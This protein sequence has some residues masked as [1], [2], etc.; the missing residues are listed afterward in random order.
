[1]LSETY[2]KLNNYELAFKYNK[3]FKK[4]SDSLNIEESNQKITTLQMQNEFRKQHQLTTIQHQRSEMKHG[5]VS[6]GLLMLILVTGYLIYQQRSASKQN[7]RKQRNLELANQLLVDELKFKKNLMEDNINYLMNKNDILTSTIE[8]LNQL[9]QTVKTEN[10]KLLNEVILELR[11]GINDEL[12]EE[13]DLRF[14]QIHNDFY[15]R[16]NQ[17]FPGLTANEIKLCA[18]L[19]LNLK[20]KDIAAITKQSIKS[21]E[22]ARSRLRKKLNIS[23]SNISLTLFLNQF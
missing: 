9:K 1:M 15:T 13:F 23:N 20:S 4:Y 2:A 3:L 16:L 6:L 19:K 14:K 22:T 7:K 11:G 18:F 10:Q 8:R 12:W 5:L 17:Q 21:V